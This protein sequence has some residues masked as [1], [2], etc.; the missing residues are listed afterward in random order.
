MGSG[1]I[2]LAAAVLAAALAGLGGWISARAEEHAEHQHAE[3]PGT[4][5]AIP[6][7]L[8]QELDQT[9]GQLSDLARQPAPVGPAA[10][11]VLALFKAHSSH[12]QELIFPPLALAP[13]IAEGHITPDMK[14]AVSAADQL[15]AEHEEVFE[16]YTKLTD[17]LNNL[18]TAAETAHN[19]EALAIARAEAA[20]LLIDQELREPMAII[21]GEYLRTKLGGAH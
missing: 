14:W 17:A 1:R 5:H 8:R 11:Q 13:A 12:E 10:E 15:K 4:E 16:H 9:T 3:H 2:G 7:S 19:P 6:Q 18:A 21:I 20:D